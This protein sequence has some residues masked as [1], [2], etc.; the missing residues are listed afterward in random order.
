MSFGTEDSQDVPDDLSARD[1][2]ITAVFLQASRLRADAVTT[3]WHA[4]WA[5]YSLSCLVGLPNLDVTNTTTYSA[6]LSGA[7]TRVTDSALTMGI[8]DSDGPLRMTRT[9]MYGALLR[10]RPDRTSSRTDVVLDSV[11]FVQTSVV[12]AAPELTP[13]NLLQWQVSD[14]VFVGMRWMD[15]L[16]GSPFGDDRAVELPLASTFAR[17][18]FVRNYGWF[19]LTG[20]EGAFTNNAFADPQLTDVVIDPRHAVISI[21][22]DATA[23]VTRNS[24]LGF[25]DSLGHLALGLDTT[26]GDA[27]TRATYGALLDATENDYGTT[28]AATVQ[29]LLH[30]RTDDT[31]FGHY[32]RPTPVLSTRH[33]D[34]PD[35]APWR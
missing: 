7:D 2:H 15:Q 34:T 28:D 25:D 10:P 4:P 32:I 17:N 27:T 14:S 11:R 12:S 9:S 13:A 6:T 5:G 33:A 19:R 21:A 35:P 1:A 29:R 3:T 22:T 20:Q 26:H 23:T 30:D 8:V 31:A 24:F 18:V 16:R